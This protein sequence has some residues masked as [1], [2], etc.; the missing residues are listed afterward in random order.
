MGKKQTKEKGYWLPIEPW[1]LNEIFT[2]E[3][4]SP[5]S[6]YGLRQFGNKVSRSTQKTEGGNYLILFTK[7][8]QSDILLFIPEYSLDLQGENYFKF[9]I[10]AQIPG[11]SG[12]NTKAIGYFKT[13]FLRKGNFS[14]Y[15]NSNKIREQFES[16]TFLLLEVK[17][18]SKYLNSEQPQIV[19]CENADN[20]PKVI[21]LQYEV[22]ELR[23]DEPFKDKSINHIK[24]LIYGLMIGQ[25]GAFSAD[26][27]ALISLTQQ[28]KNLIGG[29]RTNIVL[30]EKY[31]N[32]WLINIGAE[33]KKIKHL[34][35]KVFPDQ[36]QNAL[37][38]I[39]RRL[40]EVDV[41]NKERCLELER[42]GEQEYKEKYFQIQANLEIERNRLFAKEKTIG[43]SHFRNELDEIK[44]EERK[45]GE[46]IGKTRKFFP[47]GS[48]EYNKKKELKTLIED[49]ELNPEY[50]EQKKI[51]DSL[52]N[53]A[54]EFS[55]GFTKYD[56]TIDEQFNRVS[57]TVNSFL[58]IIN[59]KFISDKNQ[60]QRLIELDGFQL[61]HKKIWKHYQSGVETYIDVVLSLPKD[62]I[63]NLS[64]E[65][66]VL[67]K[68]CINAILSIPQ[69][70][71][72]SISE[73]HIIKLIEMIGKQLPE[74]QNRKHLRSYYEYRTNRKSSFNFPENGIIRNLLVFL[75]KTNGYDQINKMM[76][77]R[78]ING[79]DI[80]FSF[81]GA[82]MGF[83]N[84]PKTFTN[85]IF[86][87]NNDLIFE[88][89]DNYLFKYYIQRY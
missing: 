3:S 86:E 14:V 51:V 22:S 62:I 57:D 29:S 21:K 77:N 66:L 80:T 1:N 81:W 12:S 58:R 31:D 48:F 85:I 89:I 41:L 40:L 68:V 17:T 73:Q 52:A 20:L 87:S 67:F 28:L 69:G 18:V 19:F 44:E 2:S 27:Q 74:G 63:D 75:I 65:D 55:F 6:F 43:V 64:D 9:S 30:S 54:K 4:I 37:D 32:L 15:F 82:F 83:S 10:R 39:Q 26:E 79:K 59:Q 53:E 25:I 7:K 23:G 33:I 84:L 60:T 5:I 36:N 16:N 49:A 42:Q 71:V 38:S 45:M 13:I 8:I 47:K 35:K 11:K 61:D 56:S 76:E 50:L 72:G 24:G 78:G 70:Y 88:H 34:A 46:A